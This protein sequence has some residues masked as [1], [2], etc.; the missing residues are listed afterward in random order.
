MEKDTP[1]L[2][3]DD[4]ISSKTTLHRIE[5]AIGWG[6]EYTAA[7]IFRGKW[8]CTVY[9]LEWKEEEKPTRSGAR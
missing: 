8:T 1:Y 9:F 4:V 6:A 7:Y 2:F 3:V 5:T